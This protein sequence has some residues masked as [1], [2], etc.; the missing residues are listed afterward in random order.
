[1]A[2]K[3]AA[4]L[5]QAP[6]INPTVR[7][8]AVMKNAAKLFALMT[9][10]AATRI[11]IKSVLMLFLERAPKIKNT[12]SSRKKPVFAVTSPKNFSNSIIS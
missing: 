10:T 11:G 2:V 1:M 6:A 3:P 7:P 4:T 8:L 5:K 12:S 9:P